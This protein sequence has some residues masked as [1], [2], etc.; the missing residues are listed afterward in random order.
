MER[1]VE[2]QAS[3]LQA[4]TQLMGQNVRNP[5][6]LLHLTHTCIGCYMQELRSGEYSALFFFYVNHLF[7][8]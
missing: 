2:V 4:Q 6:R 7:I 1:S 8:K 3:A 5:D